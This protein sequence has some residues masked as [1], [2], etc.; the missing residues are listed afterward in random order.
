MNSFRFTQDSKKVN[1]NQ[2]HSILL[3]ILLCATG[4]S[5]CTREKAEILTVP[6]G[7]SPS[8]IKADGSAVLPSGRIINPAGEL[9]RIT[10]DPFGMKLSPDG[11]KAVTLHDGVLQ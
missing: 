3:F 11:K 10:D 8:E 1:M 4:I 2:L 6:A 5:S 7:N 9:I